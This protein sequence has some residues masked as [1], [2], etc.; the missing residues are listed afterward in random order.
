ML[1]NASRAT[2]ATRNAIRSPRR[3]QAIGPKQ[4]Y[5]L[6]AFTAVFAAVACMFAACTML[7]AC[8][9]FAAVLAAIRVA[10]RRACAAA[11][12]QL[13]LF[14]VQVTHDQLPLVVRDS[15]NVSG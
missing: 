8:G 4:R 9:M 3:D 15:E 13:Q 5:T 7:A 10:R 1:S 12:D 6:P 14:G 11:V 2:G